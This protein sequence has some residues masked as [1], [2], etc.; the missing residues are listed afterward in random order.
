MADPFEVLGLGRQAS[1]ADVRAARRR[2]AFEAHPD[3][4]GD[5]TRMREINGAFDAAVAH[6]TGR[7]PLDSAQPPS[8]PAGARSDR[9]APGSS[10]WSARRPRERVVRG[11]RRVQHDAPSFVIEALPVEAYEALLVVASWIGEVLVDEPP[12]LLDTHLDQPSPC[13]CRLELVPDAGSST[14]SLTVAGVDGELPPDVEEVRD[15][16]VA[17]LNTLGRL[18]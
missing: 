18:E 11:G 13:W 17:Q 1:L 7:R 6:L 4:G 14:V 16:W 12:Y 15:L 9:D 3:R 10:G 2:L 8:P 5:E